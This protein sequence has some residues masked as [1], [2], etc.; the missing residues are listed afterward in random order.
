M[1]A[2]LPRFQHLKT[3]TVRQELCNPSATEYGFTFSEYSSKFKIKTRRNKNI[4]KSFYLP[5]ATHDV[6][7]RPTKFH[8]TFVK[9]EEGEKHLKA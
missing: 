9:Q 3:H 5:S 8:S 1:H 6:F 2:P 4:F 7:F